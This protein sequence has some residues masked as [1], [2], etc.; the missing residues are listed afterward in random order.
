MR[1]GARV[2]IG[3]EARVRWRAERERATREA[4][5]TAPAA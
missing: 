2:L 4:A 3:K 5:T 1:A